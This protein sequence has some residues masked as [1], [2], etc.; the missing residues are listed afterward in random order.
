MSEN[1]CLFCN[2]AAQINHDGSR[3]AFW[4]ICD[5]C[6][7]YLF[8]GTL[9]S[10]WQES[11]REKFGYILSGLSRELTIN[12]QKLLELH[13]DNFEDIVS[14]FPVPN[15]DDLDAKLEKLLTAIYHFS[16]NEFGKTV[17]LAYETDYP[18]AY[19]RNRSEFIAFITQLIESGLLKSSGNPS[20]VWYPVSLSASGW[21][22]FSRLGG[23]KK[24]DQ[25][26]VAAWFDPSM[27]DSIVSIKSAIEECGFLP[28][29]INDEHFGETIMDKALGEIRRSRF[30]VIDLT[31]SR[32]SVFYEAG[33]A[34]ALGIEA[35]FV[36][37]EGEVLSGSQL[38]FYV[39]HYRCDKYATSDKL[40]EIVSNAIR[41]RFT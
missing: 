4:C 26:F 16:Q 33:F 5:R 36:Y 1:T 22:Y 30:V 8:S 3:D 28:M 14:K 34:R 31:G 32:S 2:K 12:K 24:S 38:E 10:T 11:D 29:C 20:T 39:R 9:A 7:K 6:G 15:M 27:N 41:A 17:N 25:G 19:A 21:K 37:R 23:E 40:K 18:L 35:I 13:S